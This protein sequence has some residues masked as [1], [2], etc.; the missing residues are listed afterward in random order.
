MVY[1]NKLHELKISRTIMKMVLKIFIQI[2][3]NNPLDFGHESRCKIMMMKRKKGTK[4]ETIFCC[5]R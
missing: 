2:G 1:D 4:Y 3:M 5:N